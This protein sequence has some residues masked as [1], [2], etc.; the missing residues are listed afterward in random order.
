[1]K[2]KFNLSVKGINYYFS[3]MFIYRLLSCLFFII[4]APLIILVCLLNPKWR[5]GL[6]QKYGFVPKTKLIKQGIWLHA[7]SFGEVKTIEPLVRALQS[8]LPK[9][10]IYLSTGTRTGQDLAQKLFEN[11]FVFYCPF[12]FYFAVKQWLNFLQPKMLLI[13]E[14]EIWP[15]LLIQAY[16]AKAKI[17]LINARLTD[18]SIKKYKFVKPIIQKALASFNKILAQTEDDQKRFL[19][20]GAEE[21]Q[22]KVLGNLKFASMQKI[23]N[24]SQQ[25]LKA[26]L[27]LQNQTFVLIAGSTHSPEEE[28]ICQI[29]QKLLQYFPQKDLRLI[30]APRHLERLSEI[31]NIL[32]KENLIYQKK[33][34]LKNFEPQ[35]ILLLDT[36]GE[37]TSL[38][39]VCNLAF[40]GGTWAKIGG[41]NPLEPAAYG[42]PIFVGPY[43]YKISELVEQLIEAKLL[44]QIENHDLLFEAIC[45]SVEFKPLVKTLRTNNILEQTLK[46][47]NAQ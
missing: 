42:L 39:S 25:D 13:A 30:L 26:Q 7:V 27:N 21:K 41:H 38:Y 37:L 22:L 5:E 11:V 31:E 43:T 9:T 12:D 10:P 40:L 46:I 15:E 20:I 19:Q 8:N 1:M 35:Q 23:S 34:N 16:K 45:K 29:F 47:I 14:T 17:F 24:Q 3:V 36:M 28:I 2:E 6:W 33:S 18:K 4:G 32:K 44:Q